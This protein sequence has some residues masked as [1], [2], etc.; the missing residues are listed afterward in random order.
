MKRQPTPSPPRL[1]TKLFEWYCGNASV[2]DLR[3]DLEELFYSN[4]ERG[5]LMRAQLKYW[6]QVLSLLPS[7]ALKKR[8]HRPGF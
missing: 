7:Y 8:K 2:E 1:A 4:L 6:Q 3:G 5:S